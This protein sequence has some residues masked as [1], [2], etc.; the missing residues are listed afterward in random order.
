[1]ARGGAGATA[2]G[3]NQLTVDRRWLEAARKV[4][5]S[6]GGADGRTLVSCGAP[7]AG[8]E[9]AVVEPET[10][11]R[12]GDGGVGEVWLR[13]ACVTAGYFGR[14]ELGASV[15]QARRRWPP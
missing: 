4:R 5:P 2:W 15:F 1:M 3:T 11:A 13:S 14:P 12:V 7:M 10:A 9:V 8:V 6:P